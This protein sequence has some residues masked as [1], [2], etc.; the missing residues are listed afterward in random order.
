M[1]DTIETPTTGPS[2]GFESEFA[3]NAEPLAVELHRRGMTGDSLLHGW[4]CDC[5]YC[6]GGYEYPLSVQRD[7]TVDGEV[8]S[9]PF[10]DW[11]EARAVMVTLQQAAVEVDAEPGENAGLH[12]HVQR[13]HRVN[14]RAEAFLAYLAW[15]PA[16][17]TL[18]Q[19]RF[20]YLRA[21]NRMVRADIGSYLYNAGDNVTRDAGPTIDRLVQAL[22]DDPGDMDAREMARRLYGWHYE[23]DRH[24]H[25]NLKTRFQT[26]E[27]RIWN[28]TRSAWRIELACRLAQAWTQ[29]PLVE[30]LLT[31]DGPNDLSGLVDVIANNAA[32][33]TLSELVTRQSDYLH[34]AEDIP[35][36][37]FAA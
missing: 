37:F 4:H 12:V 5:D 25:L 7:S 16:L 24:S 19:G 26:W 36:L 3:R 21:M 13:P 31:H 11:E 33:D 15:E 6:S 32:D 20:P 23:N 27:F 8:I 9:R 28:S 17:T 35:T 29:R 30:A 14:F 22:K 1:P 34:R 2:F 18:A 10:T